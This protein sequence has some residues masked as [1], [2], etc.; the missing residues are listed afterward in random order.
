MQ[1]ND[2]MEN[3]TALTVTTMSVRYV[4]RTPNFESEPSEGVMWERKQHWQ[5]PVTPVTVVSWLR[6]TVKLM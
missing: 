1:M 6:F 5:T 4:T 3:L 2:N